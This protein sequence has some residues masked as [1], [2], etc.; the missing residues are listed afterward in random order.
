MPNEQ[1]FRRR[2]QTTNRKDFVESYEG[3]LNEI[4]EDFI[5]NEN[6]EDLSIIEIFFNLPLN[7]IFSIIISKLNFSE[8]EEIDKIL[9]NLQ[10]LIQNIIQVHFEEND[11]TIEIIQNIIKNIIN[12]HFKEKEIILILQ[13][14][15]IKTISFSF[16]Y[17]VIFLF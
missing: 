9:N 14:F 10:V 16:S 7:N 5:K 4:I 13:N 1:S 17:E 6:V 3:I 8:I 11:K 15:N 12:S 2:N